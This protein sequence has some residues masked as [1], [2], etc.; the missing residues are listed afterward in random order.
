MLH[1]QPP[2]QNLAAFRLPP[3]FRGRPAWFCQLWWLV[4]ELLVR[5]SPQA[6]FAWRAWWWRRFGAR[7]GRR[8]R[9]RPGVRLTYP[10]RFEAGDHVWIGDSVHL[11]N[12]APIHVGSHSVISQGSH[13]CTGDHDPAD[14]SFAIRCHPIQV[15]S[16]AWI[17]ADCFIGP[18]VRIGDGCV[19]GARSVVFRDMPDGMVCHGQPC[20]P[21]RPRQLSALSEAVTDWQELP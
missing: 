14:A 15:G 21:K 1:L 4:E 13:L 10:W 16:Q 18:G 6:A 9:I 2:F 7:L 11:F 20:K 12:L 19:I 8:V 3:G 17:A 5:P